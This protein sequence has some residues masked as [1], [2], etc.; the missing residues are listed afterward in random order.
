MLIVDQRGDVM[1]KQSFREI[2]VPTTVLAE[3]MNNDDVYFA[4]TIPATKDV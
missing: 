4:L 3:A 1:V 2:D